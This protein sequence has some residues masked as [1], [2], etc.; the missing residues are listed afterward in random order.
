MVDLEACPGS[1]SKSLHDERYEVAPSR[2]L[3]LND[4]SGGVE[5]GEIRQIIVAASS[6]FRIHNPHLD[7]VA[8]YV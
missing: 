8:R 1:G 5:C 6:P 3:K 4:A 2:I 7:R